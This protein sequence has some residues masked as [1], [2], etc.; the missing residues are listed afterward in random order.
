MIAYGLL[1]SEP[2]GNLFYLHAVILEI[3]KQY[4]IIKPPSC[5]GTDVSIEIYELLLLFSIIT[6]C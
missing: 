1:A 2:V 5:R 3:P 6:P 4:F